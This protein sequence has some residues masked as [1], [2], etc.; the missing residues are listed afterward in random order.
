MS[1]KQRSAVA[2]ACDP[3]RKRRVKCEAQTD[4]TLCRRCAKLSLHCTFSARTGAIATRPSS[5]KTSPG[6]SDDFLGPSAVSTRLG[7]T[8]VVGQ[9]A[10][11][12][13]GLY[14]RNVGFELPGMT[15][16]P[17]RLAF[18]EAA[19]RPSE[20]NPVM[21]ARLS[22]CLAI[23]A[24]VS[25]HP[26]IIGSGAPSLTDLSRMRDSDLSQYAARRHAVCIELVQLAESACKLEAGFAIPPTP[27]SV[28]A[29]LQLDLVYESEDTAWKGH[30]FTHTAMSQL[31]TL[32]EC[33]ESAR[34]SL[35]QVEEAGEH[36]PQGPLKWAAA[37]LDASL[38]ARFRMP[39][40]IGNASIQHIFGEALLLPYLPV[41]EALAYAINR[42][43]EP[44]YA[45]NPFP[46][47][48]LS[49][50]ILMAT[51]LLALHITP[52]HITPELIDL[53]VLQQALGL[54][55]GEVQWMLDFQTQAKRTGLPMQP[56]LD[57]L[58]LFMTLAVSACEIANDAL[59][60]HL[61][62]TRA[63]LF[64]FLDLAP[65]SHDGEL[66]SPQEL[67]YPSALA[68]Q[69][70]QEMAPR[71]LVLAR[72]LAPM[73]HRDLQS[74]DSI[75][76]SFHMQV[77]RTSFGRLAQVI[78]AATPA[79]F[80]ATGLAA[81]LP[82]FSAQ[83]KEDELRQCLE[84]LCNLSWAYPDVSEDIRRIRDALSSAEPMPVSSQDLTVDPSSLFDMSSRHADLPAF[85]EDNLAHLL[86]YT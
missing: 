69:L 20:M 70:E 60:R 86:S 40:N 6:D 29:V 77:I 43:R 52:R 51:R 18:E 19:R 21:R 45:S 2:I 68:L 24:R 39:L 84:V 83:Q 12:L 76:A 82:L 71:R 62:A 5:S 32:H 26:L 67:T 74:F 49:R 79:E 9:L 16:E 64:R 34:L 85:D 15:V 31:L 46:L 72:L 78:S 4:S 11:H 35:V 54:I 27:D 36:M 80:P 30:P 63:G 66:I 44:S 10:A 33:Q 47:F 58:R 25:D 37:I 42:S 56:L 59:L 17:V 41:G 48:G 1:G 22:L 7:A 61:Q 65:S 38:A 50:S 53:G 81:H 3:C 73:F 23:A 75:C 13:L 28:A 55:D 14:A 8:Q 57:W